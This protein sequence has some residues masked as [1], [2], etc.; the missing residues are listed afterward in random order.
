MIK[1][2]V[3]VFWDTLYVHVDWILSNHKNDSCW[4][5]SFKFVDSA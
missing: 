1:K 4:I 5:S 3:D 2:D